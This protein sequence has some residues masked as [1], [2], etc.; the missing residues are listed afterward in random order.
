LSTKSCGFERGED[1][2]GLIVQPDERVKRDFVADALAVQIGVIAADEAGLFQGTHAAQTGWSGNSRPFGQRHI[3]NSAFVLEIPEN[4]QIDSVKL[5]AAHVNFRFG[6]DCCGAQGLSRNDITRRPG[7]R[8]VPPARFA[9]IAPRPEG[10][11]FGVCAD[12]P[13]GPL[14]GAGQ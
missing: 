12:S 10:H 7:L 3:R 2:L 5:D 8:Q 11:L 9:S 14:E 13:A 4:L 1:G 6:H